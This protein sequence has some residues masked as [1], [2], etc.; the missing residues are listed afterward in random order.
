M[1]L[2]KIGNALAKEFAMKVAVFWCSSCLINRSECILSPFERRARPTQSL[3]PRSHRKDNLF[4]YCL[5]SADSSFSIIENSDGYFFGN[6]CSSLLARRNVSA[7]EWDHL[8]RQSQ[9]SWIHQGMK[10]R[11]PRFLPRTGERFL[12]TLLKLLNRRGIFVCM[13][14]LIV[15]VHQTPWQR[16]P[17]MSIV[18]SIT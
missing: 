13:N 9:G 3:R 4:D 15:R 11:S 1:F 7:I 2:Q 17:P 5:A 8:E 14:Q 10:W 18:N 6:A 12:L 16:Y